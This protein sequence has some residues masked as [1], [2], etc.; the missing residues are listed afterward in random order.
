MPLVFTS[1][2]FSDAAGMEIAAAVRALMLVWRAS[3]LRGMG[4]GKLGHSRRVIGH[5]RKNEFRREGDAKLRQCGSSF[6]FVA[7]KLS[8][9]FG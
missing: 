3:M 4:A 8:H 7:I 6:Q 5:E 1:V 2:A 9:P